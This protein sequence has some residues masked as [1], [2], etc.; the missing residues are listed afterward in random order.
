MRGISVLIYASANGA[1]AQI[2]K[3]DESLIVNQFISNLLEAAADKKYSWDVFDY[4]PS[5]L[6]KIFTSIPRKQY[7][8]VNFFQPSNLGEEVKQEEEKKAQQRDFR[9]G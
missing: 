8:R 7:P 1:P 4:F 3:N 5:D 2:Q 6:Q 9:D